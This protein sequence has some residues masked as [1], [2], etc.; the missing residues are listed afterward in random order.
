MREGRSWV[1]PPAD[2]PLGVAGG[3][4]ALPT[5]APLAGTAEG[6]LR[7]RS[8]CRGS[9]G[10]SGSS[11]PGTAA[12]AAA[13]AASAAGAMHPS[14]AAAAGTGAAAGGAASGRMAGSGGGLSTTTCRPA[15]APRRPLCFC[16][17]TKL[18]MA[19]WGASSQKLSLPAGWNSRTARCPP[20]LRGGP[21][22]KRMWGTRSVGCLQVGSVLGAP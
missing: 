18:G 10:P 6:T 14:A 16:S 3:K 1:A 22:G 4:Q 9:A 5:E 13:A 7:R 2:A 12:A 20:W 8:G 21:A 11:A 15:V 19:I 17:C